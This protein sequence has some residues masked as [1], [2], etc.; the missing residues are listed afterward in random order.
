[1]TRLDPNFSY[2]KFE[3]QMVAL[4]RMAV[5]SANP[6]NLTFYRGKKRDARFDDIVD[7]TYT[8][9]MCLKNAQLKGDILHLTLRTWW[10][11]Y[12]EQQGKIKKTGDLIDVTVAKNVSHY[13]TPGFSITSVNC[14]SCGASFDAVRQRNAPTAAPNTIWKR[15]IGVLKSW[16]LSGKQMFRVSQCMHEIL[17]LFASCMYSKEEYISFY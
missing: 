9:G 4:I 13:E 17:S 10:I 3:G 16:N 11:N 7:M 6:E 12:S 8:S 14:H 5:F 1:M 15:I 2:E